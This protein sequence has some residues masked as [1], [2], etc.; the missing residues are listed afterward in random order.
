MGLF[1]KLF[2]RVAGALLL[3]GVLNAQAERIVYYHN[4]ALGSPVAATDENGELL[5]SEEYS[6]WG[7]RQLRESGSNNIAYTGKLEETALGVQYFHARWYDPDLGAFLSRD[8]VGFQADNVH[9]FNHYIYANNNPYR[10]VDPDGREVVSIDPE[11]NRVLADHINQL[12]TGRFGFD[13]NNRLVMLSATG[14]DGKSSFYTEQ[15]QFAIEHPGI[16]R[17]DINRS[18]DAKATDIGTATRETIHSRITILDKTIG[19]QGMNGWIPAAPDM[20]LAHELV[21]HAIPNLTLDNIKG[22]LPTRENIV[23]SQNGLPR[24]SG[25]DH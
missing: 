13:A 9:S 22:S 16:I 17:I 14:G 23:R 20:Q 25:H 12:A 18:P 19:L 24:R 10:Y 8:P 1:N 4:D 21:E 11:N 2:I 6:P 7:A 15:L 5:W 3:C